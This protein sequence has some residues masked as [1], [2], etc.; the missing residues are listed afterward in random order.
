MIKYLLK[1]LTR[2]H[3]LWVE[4]VEDKQWSKNVV[5]ED[6]LLECASG[7]SFVPRRTTMKIVMASIIPSCSNCNEDYT[8][9][10]LHVAYDKEEFLLFVSVVC[11]VCGED[12][13]FRWRQKDLVGFAR[14]RCE[15][16]Q[17]SIEESQMDTLIALPQP[18]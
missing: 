14:K 16:Q 11:T 10:E 13:L 17:K 8:A 1:N 7:A 6:R 2:R 5:L 3:G 12:N 9:V 15:E 18:K 4:F